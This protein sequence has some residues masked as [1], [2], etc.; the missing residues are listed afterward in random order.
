MWIDPRL[1]DRLLRV[2][3]NTAC[4]TSA[5]VRSLST[6]ESQAIG[7]QQV[8]WP[9]LRTERVPYSHGPRSETSWIFLVALAVLADSV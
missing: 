7:Q 4:A 5:T 6:L 3:N 1:E 8:G 2:S 9:S